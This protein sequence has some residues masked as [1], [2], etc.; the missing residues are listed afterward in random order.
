MSYYDIIKADSVNNY[1]LFSL[2]EIDALKKRLTVENRKALKNDLEDLFS[3]PLESVTTKTRLPP[4]GDPHDYVS[5]ATYYWPDEQSGDGLP[6]IRRDGFVNTGGL[7]QYDKDKFKRLAYLVYHGA[8]LFLLIEEPRY[9]ELIERHL[10]NWFI[11][12][13]T[14]MKAHLNY[15]QFIPGVTE[16]R[17]E[18]IID[19]SAN[20]AYALNM[21]FLLDKKQLLGDELHSGLVMWH[22]EF[23]SWLLSSPIGKAEVTAKNNHG[24]FYDLALCLIGQFLEIEESF[25]IE[26]FVRMRIEMQIAADASLPL[27]T[28]RTKSMSYSFMALKGFL[29]I[30]KLMRP[31]GIYLFPQLKS[32][33]DWLYQSAIVHKVGWTY[34]QVAPFD[35]GIYVLFREMVSSAYPG[36][37][38]DIADYLDVEKIHNR[39]LRY[40]F[41]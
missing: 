7:K 1:Y 35:A 8:L 39:V 38:H 25:N 21:L 31:K 10:Y 41:L 36:E 15:G 11:D 26:T 30:A 18:G 27:E 14:R 29:E 4:S 6:Y 40:L 19:Y 23:R 37:Y 12:P 20:F 5:L 34:E 16:G 13:C 33:V 28:A 32:C 17:A 2:E 9:S 22:K 24:T 3:W